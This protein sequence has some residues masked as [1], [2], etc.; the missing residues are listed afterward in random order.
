[1]NNV[2][3]WDYYFFSTLFVFYVVNKVEGIPDLPEE[4]LAIILLGWA[5]FP[6]GLFYW[7]LRKV[8]KDV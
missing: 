6:L 7:I 1:M 4:I 3:F 2:L 8:G 5:I